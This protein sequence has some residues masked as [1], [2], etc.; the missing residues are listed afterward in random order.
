MIMSYN[1]GLYF[2]IQ[3]DFI[4][5]LFITTW[6]LQYM[7]TTVFQTGLAKTVISIF[8]FLYGRKITM[9]QT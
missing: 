5:G 4:I 1:N 3:Y 6:L 7:H 8:F 9:C 2:Y